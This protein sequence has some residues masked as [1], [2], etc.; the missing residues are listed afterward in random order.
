[1]KLERF[2]QYSRKDIHDIL[3]PNSIYTTGS[4]KWGLQ[5]IIKIDKNKNDFVFFVT[6]GHKEKDH[7]FN[8]YID[9]NKE[10]Y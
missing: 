7:L 5:G 1:M 8:E 9:N 6:F 3:E 10:I 4:G 2:K